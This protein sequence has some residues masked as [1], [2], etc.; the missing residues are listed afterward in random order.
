MSTLNEYRELKIN[1][2]FLRDIV[3]NLHAQHAL[4]DA[5]T[6][7]ILSIGIL[8]HLNQLLQGCCINQA[9]SFTNYCNPVYWFGQILQ[10]LQNTNN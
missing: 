8:K 3:F 5:T 7:A 9:D 10:N 4:R 2:N 1:E 6:W